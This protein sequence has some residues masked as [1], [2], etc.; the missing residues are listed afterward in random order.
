MKRKYILFDFA[1]Q[2]QEPEKTEHLK[3]TIAVGYN[4]KLKILQ[5]Y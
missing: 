2:N 5:I 1:I 3:A 4:L